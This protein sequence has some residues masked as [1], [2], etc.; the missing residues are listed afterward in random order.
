MNLPQ[1]KSTFH[2]MGVSGEQLSHYN[3]SL[4]QSHLGVTQRQHRERLMLLISG[5]KSAQELLVNGTNYIELQHWK[6]K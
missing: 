1:Y 5:I 2:V 3:D 4:L 6:S